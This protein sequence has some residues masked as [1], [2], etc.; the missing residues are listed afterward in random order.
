MV[1]PSSTEFT[2]VA[3]LSSRSITSAACFVTS[4]PDIPI[5]TPMSASFIAGASF[6]PS[7]VIAQTCPRL[8]NAFTILSLCSGVTLA[9]TRQFSI[10]SSSCLSSILSSSSPV[11]AIEPAFIMPASFAIAWAV[12]LWSPVIIT[13]FMPAR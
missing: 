5:D 1:L 3:K 7:P 6:T 12:S 13:V 11:K 4:V 2:R 9:N 8:L 10:T